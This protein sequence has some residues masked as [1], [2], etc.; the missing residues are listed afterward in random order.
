MARPHHGD[1][2]HLVRLH[3]DLETAAAPLTKATIARCQKKYGSAGPVFERGSSCDSQWL[4]A[5]L[6][7]FDSTGWIEEIIMWCAEHGKN[8]DR[9]QN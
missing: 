6:A 4:V 1:R 2:M 9:F 7:A 5:R 8:G 3:L